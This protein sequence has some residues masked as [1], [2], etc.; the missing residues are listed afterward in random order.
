MEQ[1]ETMVVVLTFLLPQ[2]G[3]HFIQQK[4][5]ER[6]LAE[7]YQRYDVVMENLHK[8]VDE[9]NYESISSISTTYSLLEREISTIK[10]VSTWPWQ[11]ETVR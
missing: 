8:S 10:G 4:E 1:V 3:I 11:P 2:I 5:R 6:L 7:V 9:S